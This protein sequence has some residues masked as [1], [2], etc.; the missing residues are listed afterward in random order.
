MDYLLL[1]IGFLLLLLALNVGGFFKIIVWAASVGMMLYSLP[2][3]EFMEYISADERF[4][5]SMFL[6]GLIQF[7]ASITEYKLFGIVVFREVSD[8][9]IHG[10]GIIMTIAGICMAV[11]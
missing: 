9:I 6:V 2:S 10:L 3:T 4:A 11:F 5:A 7:F 8:F 1:F